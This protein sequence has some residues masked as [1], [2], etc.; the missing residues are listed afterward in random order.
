MAKFACFIL[1]QRV[2][3]STGL[4]HGEENY[5][6]KQTESIFKGIA[7]GDTAEEVRIRFNKYFSKQKNID[8]WRGL[9][10]SINQN[11][12]MSKRLYSEGGGC[13]AWTQFAIRQIK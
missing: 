12:T 8:F 10:F 7:S 5:I 1:D 6:E 3:D 9:R 2:Q 13:G 11:R 4:R